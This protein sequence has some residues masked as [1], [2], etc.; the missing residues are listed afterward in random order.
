MLTFVPPLVLSLC[1]HF[2]GAPQDL[3]SKPAEDPEVEEASEALAAGQYE[4]ADTLLTRLLDADAK[5]ADV[6]ELR[7]IARFEAGRID[8]AKSDADALL[9][10][11]PKRARP[12][13]LLAE[14]LG[15]AGEYEKALERAQG[16]LG[17]PLDRAA[18]VA[19]GAF[20]DRSGDEEAGE[21]SARD[22]IRADGGARPEL[23]RNWIALGAAYER[24]GQFEEASECYVSAEKS[25]APLDPLAPLDALASLGAIYARVYRQTDGYPNGER[26]F[27]EVLKRNPNHRLALLG[28]FRIGRENFNL[29]GERTQECL[30]LLLAADPNDRDALLPQARG[31]VDDRRFG[32]ARG[33]VDRILRRNPRDLDA[34]AEQAA[35]DFLQGRAESHEKAFDEDRE[36]RPRQSRFPRVLGTHLKSLYRFADAVPVLEEAAK[37]DAKDGDARTALGE[38]LAHL[39]REKEALAALRAAEQAEEGMKHPWRENMITVLGALEKEYLRAESA[40]FVFKLHPECDPVLRE[41]LPPFYEATRRDYADRYGYAPKEKVLVEV[42]REWRDFSVRSVGFT[43]FGALGVCFGPVITSVSPL[44]EEFR[45]H[46]SYLDTA[47]HE[48]AHVVHLALS[49]GRVPRWFTEGLATLEEVKRNPAY[50]RHMELDLLEARATGQIYPVME[51]NGAFRGPRILFGYYQGGLLCEYLEKKVGATR[52]PE[53]L[54]LFGEDRPLDEVIQSAF[55][56]GVAELDRGFLAFVDEK[57][58][59][60]R[61]RAR[62]D[63]PTLKRLRA[64]T[65]RN[66]KDPEPYRALA[67][68]CARAGRIVDAE[69]WLAGLRGAAPEDAEAWLVRGEL[70]LARKRPDLAAEQFE[71][72]FAGGAEEFF[73]RM[74]YAKLLVE[75]KEF[76]KASEQLRA[77]NA[78]FPQF[79]DERQSPRVLLAKLLA[80]E[81]KVDESVALLEEFCRVS[82]TA[83]APRLELAARYQARGDHGS[84]SRVLGELLEVDPFQRELQKRRARCL[85]E[86]GQF[87]EAAFAAKLARLVDPA[88]EPRDPR[89]PRD[90]ASKEDP[91]EKAECFALEAEALWRAKKAE[92]AR[93]ALKEAL[94]LDPANER[95]LQLRE[96][97]GGAR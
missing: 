42:F 36:R 18:R 47:W 92:A 1:A 48:Y 40:S 37:R 12:Q 9:A 21:R 97:M 79:A 82:G 30:A 44:A 80:D 13:L 72:G 68:A 43:G 17:G 28:R 58:E 60:V 14:I 71:K 11:D 5:D 89:A 3:A 51:L 63:A 55:G 15:T 62:L 61:V 86:L 90:G 83:R 75:R 64:A 20:Q 10:G 74:A 78:A 49:K 23:A 88:R 94:R 96:Q 87:E 26:E 59:T 50:D 95:A 2:V 45:A 93:G 7:M 57:L 52:F 54:R 16:A 76:A 6:R 66:P 85:L 24:V 8:D 29:D 38:C 34:L 32:D 53:A 70:S 33:L 41:M 25:K 19:I 77:A 84:E 69:G 46:F 35:L 27:K 4:K 31:F 81:G 67:W 22:A 91:N 73:S 56:L 39:G 65:V